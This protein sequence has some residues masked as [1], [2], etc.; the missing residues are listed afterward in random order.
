MGQVRALTSK[1]SQ[2]GGNS[3]VSSPH[4]LNQQLRVGGICKH[5][6]CFLGGGQHFETLQGDTLCISKAP[7]LAS[8]SS[9]PAI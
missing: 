7:N 5:H 3:Q 4:P 1:N 6:F 2:I 9:F 8:I